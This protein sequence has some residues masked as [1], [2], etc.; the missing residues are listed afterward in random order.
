MARAD[1]IVLWQITISHY[2]EKVRWALEHKHI[3]HERRAPPPGL[4]MFLAAILTR[5]RAFTLP[6][7]E[8]EGERIPDSAAIIA[9]LEARYPDPPLY[10][11][12]AAELARA[13]ARGVVRP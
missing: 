10:P 6:I 7:L 11:H 4:H 3:E 9:A 5:G 1:H 8:L 2:S 12:D 13:G